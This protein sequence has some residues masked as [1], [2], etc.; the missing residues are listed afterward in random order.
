MKYKDYYGALGVQKTASTEEIKKAYR[1]L[2]R[3]YHPD[4]SKE[5]D[6]EDK[7]KEIGEAYETLQDPKKRDAY[8]NLGSYQS[9]QEFRPP[10]N[11]EGQFGGAHFNFDGVD[12]A[13]LLASLKGGAAG[14]GPGAKFSMPGQ[15]FEVTSSIT[16]DQAN[17]GTEIDL[18]LSVPEY[19]ENGIPR[20][21]SRSFKARVPKGVTDGHKLRI[22]GKGGKGWN[23]GRDGDLY[24]NIA[25]QPHP[26]YRVVGHDLY[27]DLPLSSWEAVL[28]AEVTVPT[29]QGQVR[30]KVPPGT[31]AG[32]KL[33]L[34]GRGL[35]KPHSGQ[36]DLYAVVHIVVP[37][38]LS[39]KERGL[40]RELAGS[41]SF[42]PRRHFGEQEAGRESR[43]Q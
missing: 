32:Q 28:G 27:L 40:F 30:L 29:L 22:P 19:G 37:T 26:L 23:G 6:A 38:E 31:Q 3:K 18:N 33:R 9:G 2:A 20:R 8:D 5:P 21:V 42:D 36:G 11:W 35:S 13:D 43:N 34:A 17:R 10:P 24:L 39:E 4:L 15:D 7:F 12:L 25:L 1:R 14:A 16:L 41:S